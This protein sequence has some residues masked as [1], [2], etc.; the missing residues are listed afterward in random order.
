MFT[1]K[2]SWQNI[3]MVS[4][5]HQFEP[6]LP[7][8]ARMEPLLAKAHD[9]ARL[10]TTLVGTRVPSELRSLLWHMN[11]YYT[12][13][14]EGQHTRPHEIDQALRQDFSKDAALAA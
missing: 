7:A 2:I 6:L 4:Q 8:D 11:S 5:V 1:K 12:N 10:A 9:L 3:N 13:R 14:I